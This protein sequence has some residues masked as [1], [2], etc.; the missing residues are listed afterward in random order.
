MICIFLRK[1]LISNYND[2][3]ENNLYYNHHFIK[4]ARILSTDKLLYKEINSALTLL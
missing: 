4:W 3:D 1:V 2:A